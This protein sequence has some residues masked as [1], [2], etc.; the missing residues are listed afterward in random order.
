[1]KEEAPVRNKN[2]KNE[3]SKMKEEAPV[4]NKNLK[5]EVKLKLRCYCLARTEHT[6]NAFYALPQ[7]LKYHQWV[8]YFCKIGHVW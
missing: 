2:L 3:E 1:M 4:R 6:M 8:K 7:L 5:N